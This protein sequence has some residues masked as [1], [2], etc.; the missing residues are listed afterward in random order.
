M[1]GK[2]NKDT[3][4]AEKNRTGAWYQELLQPISDEMPCGENL[5]YDAGF[6][7][8]QSKLQ[9]RLDAEY[10]SFVEA[11][12]PI[13]WAE[14]ERDCLALLQKSRDIRLIIILMRC[15]IRQIGLGALT[16]GLRALRD[17]LIAFPAAIYP[18]LSEEGVYDPVMR[19]NALS[20]L[21]DINGLLADIRNQPLPKAAGLHITIK[22]FEKAHA[23][24]RE[25]GALPEGTVTA[26]LHEWAMQEEP[27]ISLLQEAW[28]N[29][30]ELRRLL[31]EPL[32]NETP[33]FAHLERLLHLFV[34][35]AEN[36][37]AA[38]PCPVQQ[39]TEQQRPQN[40]EPQPQ[41]LPVVTPKEMGN[42]SDALHKLRELRLWFM[43][44]EP[45]SP[46][47]QLLKFAEATVGKSFAELLKM[48]PAEIIEKL[49][50]EKE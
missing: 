33:D 40:E 7:M 37:E 24:P 38:L 36:D 29:L 4:V 32:G 48:L 28:H 26:L 43:K 5:E 46:V 39:P 21:E 49:D 18:Q 19:A 12:E 13:N 30:T 8:L 25:E 44:M 15:R 6:I 10:G 16:E 34:I 14:T 11:A 17:L 20:E 42:R 9:P 22:E 3:I 27:T 2:A 41:D 45:S 31:A 1:R 35:N 23:F 50:V 47:I